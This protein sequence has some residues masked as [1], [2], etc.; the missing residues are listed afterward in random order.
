LIGL[1]RSREQAG[2]LVIIVFRGEI[3]NHYYDH[4]RKVSTARGGIVLILNDKDLRVFVRQALNGK[5]KDSHLQD[6]YDRVLREIS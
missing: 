2:K 5:V 6:K 3:R 4:I 1:I